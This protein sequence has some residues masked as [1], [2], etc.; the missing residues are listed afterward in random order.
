MLHDCAL[1][2]ARRVCLTSLSVEYKAG[3]QSLFECAESLTKKELRWA[4]NYT[5]FED[6]MSRCR[7]LKGGESS[8]R[9]KVGGQLGVYLVKYATLIAFCGGVRTSG[10]EKCHLYEGQAQDTLEEPIVEKTTTS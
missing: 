8:A 2:I 3:N 4:C 6:N 10:S 5:V 9:W 1:R 7:S